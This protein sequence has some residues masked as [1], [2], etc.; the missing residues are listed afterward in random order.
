MPLVSLLLSL[1]LAS[2]VDVHVDRVHELRG[3][4]PV[5]IEPLGARV[6]FREVRF[7]D[8][9]LTVRWEIESD[10]PDFL[11]LPIVGPGVF[12]HTLTWNGEP[13]DGV[14]RGGLL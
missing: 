8:E 5:E 6:S 11:T 1:S 13:L 2:E 9:A 12:V 4:D 7:E 14:S 3:T 10:T